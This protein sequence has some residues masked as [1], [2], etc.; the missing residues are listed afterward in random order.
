MSATS[1]IGPIFGTQQSPIPIETLKAFPVPFGNSHLQFHYSRPLPGHFA[2]ENFKIDP[3][4]PNDNPKD[5]MVEVGTVP[6]YIRKI[7]IHRTPEHHVDGSPSTGT[8]LYEVHLVH[9]AEHDTEGA[10]PKLAVGVFVT[11]N[12][13]AASKSSLEQLCKK[14]KA[15]RKK[16]QRLGAEEEIR[17]NPVEFLP[18]PEKRGR[19]FQ[20]EGSL[21]TPAYSEDV[22][23]IVLKDEA[24]VQPETFD[25]L[26]SGAH[27]DTRPLQPLNRRYVLRSFS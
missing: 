12:A 10:G 7:H 5:W 9:S 22:S 13:K 20:Y 4:G 21:T 25:C 14:F 6:W 23:W 11:R 27:Q 3:P 17:L 19:W 2:D 1:V 18:E 24:G 8:P 26:A 16:G 15:A